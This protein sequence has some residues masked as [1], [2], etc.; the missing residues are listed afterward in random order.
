MAWQGAGV[1]LMAGKTWYECE[2]A[3]RLAALQTQR[4]TFYAA[5]MLAQR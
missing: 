2:L 5:A 3:S 1:W 4:A